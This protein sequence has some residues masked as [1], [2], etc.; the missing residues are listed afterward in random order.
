M[1]KLDGSRPFVRLLGLVM[2]TKELARLLPRQG[3]GIR[4]LAV[5][6]MRE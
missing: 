3:R 6:H 1:N 5:S 4:W 2:T